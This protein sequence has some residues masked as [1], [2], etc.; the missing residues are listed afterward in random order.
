MAIIWKRRRRWHWYGI[1]LGLWWRRA[2][3]WESDDGRYRVFQRWP[4]DTTRWWW[5]RTGRKCGAG[6][7][8]FRFAS[9]AMRMAE[10][11]AGY[12]GGGAI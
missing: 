5:V 11:D 7:A 3:Y 1:R 2:T 8:C 4:Y 10:R 12:F 6:E 9:D